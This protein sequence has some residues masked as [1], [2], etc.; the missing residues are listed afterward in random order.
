MRL[1]FITRIRTLDYLIGI[2]GTGAP[3]QLA[4]RLGISRSCLLGYIKAMRDEGAPIKFD[5]F[6]NSYVYEEEGTFHIDFSF[7]KKEIA[8][9][10]RSAAGYS[11]LI[12]LS[13]YF[14]PFL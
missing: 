2:K 7:Y 14:N 11:S 12:F 5:H 8:Q 4:S 10:I 13:Q 3:D 1:D 6:R 9:N